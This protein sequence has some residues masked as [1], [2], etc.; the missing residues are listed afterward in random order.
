MHKIKVIKMKQDGQIKI[1]VYWDGDE[2]SLDYKLSRVMT[3][4]DGEVD[5]GICEKDGKV[6]VEYKGIGKN[7]DF[8]PVGW[9]EVTAKDI[10]M[11]LLHRAKV[12][13]DWTD[14]IDEM[15]VYEQ[16]ISWH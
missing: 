6:Y 9:K 15:D 13:R 16:E 12:V 1:K 4:T 7:F 3:G 5:S 14:S 11:E 2:Y 10:A 8:L